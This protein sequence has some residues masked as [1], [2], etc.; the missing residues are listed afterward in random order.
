M[1]G[2]PRVA[3]IVET[4]KEYGRGLLRGIGRFLR[5]NGPW[6]ISIEE[7]D[8]EEPEPSWLPRFRGD[9]IIARVNG[10]RMARAV[11]GLGIPAVN[12]R[13]PV[14]GV[15]LPTIYGDDS[16]I[17]ELALRHFR[18][19]GFRRFAYCGRPGVSW[20]EIRGQAFCRSVAAFGASCAVFGP[21]SRRSAGG[22]ERERQD[23][24]RWLSRLP[25]PLAVLACND[26]RG[27]QVLDA[28][29]QIGSSVP[30]QVA[31]LGVDNDAVFC[32]LADPP[33]S[34]VDQDLER[35][36]F[37]AAAL[38]ARLLRGERPPAQ[39]VFVPP[40]GVVTRRST[41]AVAIDDPA[42]ASAL[43]YIRLH[44]CRPLTI[45]EVASSAAVSRRVLERR[46]RKTL[47]ETPHELI[48]GVRLDRLKHLLMETDAKL[49]EVAERSGFRYVSRMSAFFKERTGT[50]PGAY[51]RAERL[52]TGPRPAGPRDGA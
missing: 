40:R 16:G 45:G 37:E 39:P 52:F 35:I 6:S 44:A 21:D 36:G 47:G 9:G 11:S 1:P 17:V 28:C 8:V 24:G 2:I 23:V 4:S 3:V 42:I 15:E 20:S 13:Y 34:S 48:L 31:V 10:P 50:T 46:L 51:R 7:R 29:R 12:L 33:L 41:D 25:R 43:R 27:L 26:A 30:G 18:E 38:L 32:D 49:E 5:T 22:W 19:R 14:L